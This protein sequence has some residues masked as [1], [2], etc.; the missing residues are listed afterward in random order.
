MF[1]EYL[2]SPYLLSVLI[3]GRIASIPILCIPVWD[4]K[5]I[6]PNTYVYISDNTPSYLGFLMSWKTAR[7]NASWFSCSNFNTFFI[8]SR[9]HSISLLRP[10]KYS[11]LNEF[12]VAVKFGFDDMFE[13]MCFGS[14]CEREWEDLCECT[15]TRPPPS[16]FGNRSSFV[17]LPF[18][19][20]ILLS[21]D[22]LGWGQR[23]YIRALNWFP[24][25]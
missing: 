8:W 24:V 5:R 10:F 25:Q 7:T 2:N 13:F 20:N 18:L 3:V 17:F 21:S 9:R 12:T 1:K 22:N 16:S 4:H 19:P 14:N 23:V 11:N 6:K 15:M